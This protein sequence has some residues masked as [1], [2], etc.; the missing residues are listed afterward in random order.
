M[1]DEGV[2]LA[3]RPGALFGVTTFLAPGWLLHATS[4]GGSLL[5][6]PT[7]W[8][9]RPYSDSIFGAV[10][11]DSKPS[12]SLFFHVNILTNDRKSLSLSMPPGL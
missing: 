5:Q 2:P 6:I 1:S 3:P 10:L 4:V 12:A 11:I 9:V 7:A 8:I